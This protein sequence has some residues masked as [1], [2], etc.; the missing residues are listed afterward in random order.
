MVLVRDPAGQWRD[1]A[2]VCTDVRLSAAEIIT[3]YCRRW[4]VEV[5]FADAKQL[6]G[7]HD[8]QVW[9]TLAVERA[10]PMAWFVATLIVCWYAESG[11]M[12]RRPNG[13]GRGTRTRRRR[14][15][16]TCWRRAGCSYG[17]PGSRPRVVREQMRRRN[18]LG[19]W[20]MWRPAIEGDGLGPENRRKFA[21]RWRRSQ[22]L[23]GQRTATVRPKQSVKG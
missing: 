10:A 22:A 19:C 13:I 18:W 1:E 6:L 15:S 17:K 12:V 4:S 8:P 14:R 5:A 16:L 7:F 20:S 23:A 9:S 2:L 21:R 3:G 11:N